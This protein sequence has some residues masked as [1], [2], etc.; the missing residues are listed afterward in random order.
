MSF[1]EQLSRQTTSSVTNLSPVDRFIAH[2]FIYLNDG[3][4]ADSY[5]AWRMK[6]VRKLM[7]IYGIEFKGKR[8][9]ELGAGVGDIGSIFAELGAEVIGLEGRTANCNLANLRF[10]K[11]EN[12]QVLQWD[13][14]EDFSSFGRFDLIINFA[15]VEAIEHFEKLLDC[16]MT[17]SDTIFLETLVCDSTDPYKLFFVEMHPDKSCDWPLSGRS[18]RPA[19]AYIERLFSEKGFDVHQHFDSDINS[20][21]HTYDWKHQN[22][23]NIH[24]SLRRFWSFTKKGMP[25]TTSH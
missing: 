6:R 16:S 14:E 5:N 22:N 10:R 3:H 23:D 15:L 4:F 1:K 17:M 13:L 19:P 24:H 18:P 25:A 2:H 11:L 20:Y 7:E 12:Y 8:I 9:L 21:P